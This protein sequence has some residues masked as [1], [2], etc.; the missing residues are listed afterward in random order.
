VLLLHTSD[1][2]LGRLL[3]KTKKR[4]E[5]FEAF[6]DW[7]AA[8]IEQRGVEALLVAGDVFDTTTPTNRAQRLYYG[9]IKRLA[10][11]GCRHAVVT[12]GNHDSPSFL[13]APAGVLEEL[14]VHAVGFGDPIKE[15]LVLRDLQGRPELVVCAV[16]F[17]R[18]S[19]LRLAELGQGWEAREA[20][21]V[22]G[23]V[24]HYRE[25]LEQARRLAADFDAPAPLAA[26]GH[27]FMAGG[28]T[29]EGD[30][31]RTVH[32]GPLSALPP[33]V[34]PAGFDYLALGHLHSPQQVGGDPT[35]RYSGS[36]LPM[37]F[38]EIK[39]PKSVALVDLA[40]GRPAEVELVE[41]PVFQEL[42]RLEGDL[43]HLLARIARLRL[44]GSTAW[45]E[46]VHSGDGLAPAD[47]RGR[48]EDALAGSLMDALV[49]RDL[50]TRQLTMAAEDAEKALTDMSPAEVFD[51]L[52][53]DRKVAEADKAWLRAAHAEMRAAAREDDV[54]AE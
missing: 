51:Q 34:F 22:E 6:L 41:A 31:V 27:F 39:R 45:L 9:F 37:G 14:G 40:P 50:R 49:I 4:Y 11:T 47:V 28:L 20:A 13:E 10:S 29:V 48:L 5:E 15:T 54:R 53:T 2:H 36:P 38:N 3:C 1:W 25:A 42:L 12:A 18:E 16:P 19:D 17:L 23:L 43:P 21:L 44:T 24:A 26:M 8:L 32:A 33:E 7:L 52:L 35:K 30:G 46:L